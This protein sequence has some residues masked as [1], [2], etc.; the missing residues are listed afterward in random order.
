MFTNIDISGFHEYVLFDRWVAYE[1][2]EGALYEIKKPTKYLSHDMNSRYLP[3][4]G[5]QN[6][7]EPEAG[8]SSFVQGK[9]ND[10]LQEL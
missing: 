9:N 2:R 7:I 3:I 10:D 5:K 4:C 1:I 6:K 8:T